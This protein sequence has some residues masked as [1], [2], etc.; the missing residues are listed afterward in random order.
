MFTVHNNASNSVFFAKYSHVTTSKNV[1]WKENVV[2]LRRKR[3]ANGILV[4][5]PERKKPILRF[6]HTGGDHMKMDQRTEMDRVLDLSG[7]RYGHVTGSCESG[8]EPSVSI[9]YG[10]FLE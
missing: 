8:N 2:G 3:N 9:K 10:E 6:K 5:K 1:R 7:S 4:G